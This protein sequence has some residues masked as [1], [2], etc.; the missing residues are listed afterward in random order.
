MEGEKAEGGCIGRGGELRLGL[1]LGRRGGGKVE[2][3]QSS[4]TPLGRPRNVR[5]L[6]I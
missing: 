3:T 5:E 6:E 2:S 4:Y 1:L